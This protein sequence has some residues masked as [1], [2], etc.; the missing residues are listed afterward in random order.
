MLTLSYNDHKFEYDS[1]K[2]IES[3]NIQS[4]MQT[5]GYDMDQ[6]YIDKFWSAIDKNEWIIVDYAML[7]WIGYNSARDRA[8]KEKYLSLLENNFERPRDYDTVNK[9]DSRVASDILNRTIIVRAK[10][11]KSSL[12]IIRTDRANHIHDN[13]MVMQ[14]LLVDYMRYTNVINE[15]NSALKL[16]QCKNEHKK[17][18][19][20]MKATCAAIVELRINETPVEYREY[21]YILT[22][23]RYFR[24]NLFKIGK[25]IDLKNR[26]STY[27][28][29]NALDE[30]QH[31]YIATIKTT[32]GKALEK[33]LHN[34]LA[35][36]KHNKEWYNI[37]SYSLL[38]IVN[39]VNTQQD[40]LK[41]IVNGIIKNQRDEKP[42]INIDE[43]VRLAQLTTKD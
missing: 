15:H 8:N 29:G 30:D 27:N 36:Y 42:S 20:E 7:R 41:S 11:F 10:V 28:T 19:E 25:T 13:I 23:K 6:L 37:N 17:Q 31:F 26:L 18:I 9:N 14:R 39:F 43:F 16:I 35:N 40:Q 1:S 12:M 2:L 5:F 38:Q 4:F 33:Q 22:S 32:D 21:V 34:L 24:A 3:M